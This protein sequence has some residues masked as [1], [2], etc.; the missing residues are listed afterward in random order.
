M[1]YFRSIKDNIT[2]IQ[3]AFSTDL[4]IPDFANFTRKIS[5]IY[6]ACKANITGEVSFRLITHKTMFRLPFSQESLD[7]IK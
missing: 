3:K 1:Y 2:L 7:T 4:I 5:D 6:Y